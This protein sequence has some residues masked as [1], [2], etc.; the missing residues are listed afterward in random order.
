MIMNLVVSV[1]IMVHG[2]GTVQKTHAVSLQ[3]SL[4]MVF[5]NLTGF[6]CFLFDTILSNVPVCHALFRSSEY[7]LMQVCRCNLQFLLCVV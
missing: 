5:G 4:S 7:L 2:I 3:Q 1:N 6:G